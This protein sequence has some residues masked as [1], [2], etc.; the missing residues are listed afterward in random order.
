MLS[1]NGPRKYYCVYHAA[2]A[3]LRHRVNLM[4]GFIGMGDDSESDWSTDSDCDDKVLFEGDLLR[5]LGNWMDRLC[6]GTLKRFRVQYWPPMT[7][8]S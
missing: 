1:I 4:G 6:E 3:K 8:P 5:G 2:S 7:D